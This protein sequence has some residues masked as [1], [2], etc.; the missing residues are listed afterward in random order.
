MPNTLTVLIKLFSLRLTLTVK[1]VKILL[2]LKQIKDY[3]PNKVTRYPN[4]GLGAN[5]GKKRTISSK[6]ISNFSSMNTKMAMYSIK[7][8]PITRS[9]LTKKRVTFTSNVRINIT[10]TRGKK[11]RLVIRAD[12]NTSTPIALINTNPV[13]HQS[14][15]DFRQKDCRLP[16]TRYT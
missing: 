7:N 13:T 5:K 15:V 10:P 8:D 9:K 11:C 16:D 6:F 2:I 12:V 1:T 14:S 3:I 4:C